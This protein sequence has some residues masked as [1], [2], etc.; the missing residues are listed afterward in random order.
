MAERADVRSIEALRAFK[1]ALKDFDEAARQ[2]LSEAQSD[3]MRAAGWLQNDRAIYWKQ[4]LRYRQNRLA[5]ARSELMR[6]EI[7]TATRT[8]GV[9]ERKNV[10]KWKHAVEEAEH[11]LEAIKRWLRQLE[12]EATLFKGK[13]QALA[14]TVEGDFP[15]AYA[16]LDRLYEALEKYLK[17]AAPAGDRAAMPRG[18]SDG[19]AGLDEPGGSAAPASPTDEGG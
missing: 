19:G 14:R 1:A 10:E 12:R 6:A 9:V 18:S 13:C 4:Q 8:S 7:A 3:V 5:D 17:L 15:K 2:S 11:K 16:T